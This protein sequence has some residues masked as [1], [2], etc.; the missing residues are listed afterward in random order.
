MYFFPVWIDTIYFWTIMLIETWG[1]IFL[2]CNYNIL[3]KK[4]IFLS[5]YIVQKYCVW[6]GPKLEKYPIL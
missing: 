3:K 4:N 6:R 5:Q 2:K 1:E